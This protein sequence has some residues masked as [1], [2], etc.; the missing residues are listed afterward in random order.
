MKLVKEF[1]IICFQAGFHDLTP[2]HNWWLQ[3]ICLEQATADQD[4][5]TAIS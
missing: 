3:Q 5:L 4:D 2:L 1:T